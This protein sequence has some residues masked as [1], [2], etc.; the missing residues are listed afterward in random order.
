[1]RFIEKLNIAV[2]RGDIK[3]S[4]YGGI[5]IP[6]NTDMRLLLPNCKSSSYA[7]I[8]RSM[9]RAGFIFDKQKQEWKIA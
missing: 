6:R 2:Q 5:V 8:R 7:T 1:M 3:V 9:Q 4:G